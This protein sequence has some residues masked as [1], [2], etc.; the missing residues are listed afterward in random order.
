MGDGMMDRVPAS[1]VVLN[2]PFS[3]LNLNL[4]VEFV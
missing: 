1:T 2:L 3:V 4:P